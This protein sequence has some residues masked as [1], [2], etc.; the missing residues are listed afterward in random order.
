MYSLT[1]PRGLKNSFLLVFMTL[2]LPIEVSGTINPK[3]LPT[4]G[5]SPLRLEVITRYGFG[6]CRMIGNFESLLSA[7]IYQGERVI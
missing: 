7:Q 2:V 1:Y 5:P 3:Q 4:C 6:L